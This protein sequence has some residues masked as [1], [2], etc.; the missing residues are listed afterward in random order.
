MR[1]ELSDP[2]PSQSKQE[3]LT[4]SIVLGQVYLII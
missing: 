4:G 3:V 2:A 1:T